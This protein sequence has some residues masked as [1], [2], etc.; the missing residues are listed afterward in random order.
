VSEGAWFDVLA[1]SSPEAAGIEEPVDPLDPAVRTDVWYGSIEGEPD[2]LTEITWGSTLV[3]SAPTQGSVPTGVI[4]VIVTA[5]APTDRSETK[6]MTAVFDLSNA[7][8][9]PSGVAASTLGPDTDLES[10]VESLH[11]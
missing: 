1:G 8:S 3:S 10:L 4:G 11:C 6:S 9:L 5:S 7:D 2:G